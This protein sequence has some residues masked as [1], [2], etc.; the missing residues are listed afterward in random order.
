MILAGIDEAG[1]GPLLGPLVV[2]CCVFEVAGQWDA[3]TPLPCLWKKLGKLTSRNRL[4]SGRKLHI[5]DSKKVYSPSIGLKELERSILIL[6]AVTHQWCDNLE[7]LVNCVASHVVPELADYP[8]YRPC[9]GE[10]FPLEQEG[11]ALQLFAN[12]LRQEMMRMEMKCVHLSARVLP[13]GQL[14]RQLAATRN[15]ASVLFS[16]A[17]IHLDHILRNYA[18]QGP[19]IICDRHGG[20]GH[21][22]SLLRMMFPDWSLRIETETEALSEYTLTSTSGTAR[23]IFSEKAESQ[24]MSVAVASMLSKYL[25][26][27][28]MR[29]FNAWWKNHIPDLTPTA[30]YYNDGLRF[31]KDIDGKRR[32]LGIPSERLVRS[33]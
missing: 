25:R 8:W 14:N 26:E 24:S 19:V 2:G 13:E 10:R 27:A 16:T 28:L 6:N 33:R 23:I 15:K 22:G 17:A 18:A 30:G 4:K 12:A 21:Y 5:N 9:D 11:L 29:R 32:E 1:Y 7:T 31:L 20:R 3:A